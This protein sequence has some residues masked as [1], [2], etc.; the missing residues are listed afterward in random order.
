MV[1][2]LIGKSQ[3]SIADSVI[4]AKQARISCTFIRN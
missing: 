3:R 4:T 1:E 2:S